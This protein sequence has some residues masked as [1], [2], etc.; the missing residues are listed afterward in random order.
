M[1]FIG[2]PAEADPGSITRSTHRNPDFEDISRGL[3]E[4]AYGAG[5]AHTG[6]CPQGG[7]RHQHAGGQR[8]QQ[9][10]PRT[11]EVP[12]PRPDDELEYI[13]QVAVSNGRG[14]IWLLTEDRTHIRK[15]VNTVKVH[16]AKR[17]KKVQS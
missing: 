16:V 11:R 9:A 6:E 15:V 8:Q 1:F 12:R 5:G 7:G 2:S 4:R 10:P 14:E 17:K 3:R 13:I